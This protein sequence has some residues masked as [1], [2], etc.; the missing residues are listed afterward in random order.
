[1]ATEEGGISRI[2]ETL[3]AQKRVRI[4]VAEEKGVFPQS[5]TVP[6]FFK[7]KLKNCEVFHLFKK[8]I[9]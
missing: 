4:F 2:M 1:M 5:I 9:L 8:C 7:C 3:H 6:T